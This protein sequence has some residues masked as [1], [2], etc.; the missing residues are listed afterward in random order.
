MKNGAIY[1]IDQFIR[2]N[3][4]ENKTEINQRLDEVEGDREYDDVMDLLID[5]SSKLINNFK[6]QSYYYLIN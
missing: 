2:S 1:D 3:E 4:V 6:I 5:N